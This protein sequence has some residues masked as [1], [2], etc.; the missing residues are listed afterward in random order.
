MALYYQNFYILVV[1]VPFL[2]TSWTFVLPVHAVKD[3]AQVLEERVTRDL[4]SRGASPLQAKSRDCPHTPTSQDGRV[5][6]CHRRGLDGVSPSSCLLTS[7]QVHLEVYEYFLKR[8]RSKL[9]FPLLSWKLAGPQPGSTAG[10]RLPLP[11]A[12]AFPGTSKH[13]GGQSPWRQA[14]ASAAPCTC[15]GRASWNWV[16]SL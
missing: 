13:Q 3:S 5:W 4:G 15:Q 2:H 1:F 10:P 8:F 16:N 9:V 6:G 11:Q 14:G 12:A 7:R